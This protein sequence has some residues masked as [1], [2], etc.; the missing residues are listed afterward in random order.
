MVAV[1]SLLVSL[2]P[3]SPSTIYSS[4]AARGILLK[5]ESDHSPLFDILPS[6]HLSQ[7]ESP[8]PHCTQSGPLSSA[9]VNPLTFSETSTHS[10][11]ATMAS[12]IISKYARH[13]PASGPLLWLHLL[14]GLE[15]CRAGSPS[16][17]ICLKTCSKKSPPHTILPDHFIFLH[18][19]Y[20]N[21]YSVAYSVYCLF[22]LVE[23]KCY[24]FYSLL[25][26]KSCSETIWSG[27]E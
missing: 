21:V 9:P 26:H 7:R 18:C 25:E 3:S 14:P 2:P 13:I 15:L 8:G 17:S 27:S 10:A 5:P 24:T 19:A 12:L 22:L 6:S 23:C 11:P 16:S 4:P 1:A 20:F